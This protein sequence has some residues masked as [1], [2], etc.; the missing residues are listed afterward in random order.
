MMM[1]A[2]LSMSG[3]GPA[4]DEPGQ[5]MPLLMPRERLLAACRQHPI[6]VAEAPSG[7]GKSA[8]ATSWLAAAAPG[9]HCLWTAL[10]A[11]ARD[12]AVFLD[13]LIQSGTGQAPDWSGKLLD[14][15]ASLAVRFAQVSALLADD[16]QPIAL[17]LDNVH[18]LDGSRSRSYLQRLLAA[19]NPRLRIFIVMNPV[20]LEAGLA[21]LGVA[22]KLHWINAAM[23]AFSREEIEQLAVLRGK[24]LSAAQLDWLHTAT[25]GWPALVQLALLL[26][27]DR[28]PLPEA[29]NTLGPLG[30]LHEYLYDRFLSR[31]DAAGRELMWTMACLGRGT[32]R[33]LLAVHESSDQTATVLGT[34][35]DLG[36]VRHEP[37]TEPSFQLN[38]LVRESSL[39]LLAS[40]RCRSK[41]EILLAAA[42]WYRHQGMSILAVRMLLETEGHDTAMVRDWLLELGHELIFQQGQHQTLLDLEAL[43]RSVA[44]HR[45]PLLDSM[46]CWAL[47]FQRRFEEAQD[48]IAP[49]ASISRDSIAASEAT[50]QRAVIAAL[51][52]DLHAGGDL[53]SIWLSLNPEQ[54][55][56]QAGAAWTV[57]AF[58][59]KSQGRISEAQAALRDAHLSFHRVQSSYGAVWAHLVGALA[60]V[61]SGQ[62]RDALVEIQSGVQLCRNGGLDGM[63]AMLRATE[64]YIRYERDELSKVRD[65]LDEALPL[66]AEQGV[67]DSVV[68]GYAAAAR[69]RAAEGDLGAALDLLSEAERSG[70][71]RE[72]RRLSISLCAERA[73]ILVRNGASGQA[74]ETAQRADIRLDHSSGERLT[75]DRAGRLFA[76]IALADGDADQALRIVAPQLAR[77][78][79][80]RNQYKRCELLILT[81]LAESLAAH[82]AAAATALREALEIA[83]AE[84]YVRV[85]IDEGAELLVLLRRWLESGNRG[86]PGDPASLLA[87]AILTRMNRVEMVIPPNRP[88][89]LDALSKR[90]LQLLQL[91]HQGLSNAEIAARCFLVEG[92]VKWHLHNLY[93]KLGVSSRTAALREAKALGLLRS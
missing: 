2:S 67:V 50:L 42:A 60:L 20:A 39:R 61:K 3:T 33:L 78:R 7:Y 19:A 21:A 85:F 5:P 18:H 77:V 41:G 84:G 6:I 92:T 40:E 73:L 28:Q 57:F 52:D 62:H 9:S 87:E 65:L 82:H 1:D 90:E 13:A 14:D 48:R 66:L 16:A 49:I 88:A 17:V 93:G 27:N 32:M 43:W 64:A 83:A 51:R 74:R 15:D 47:I 36:V 71:Q 23:L 63:H 24:T 79:T 12:P 38:P 54:R 8:L 68:L 91:I 69:L 70:Q 59:L 45:D 86:R 26:I 58:N 72:F 25:Q 44:G 10:D 22:G 11:S 56:F 89:L 4:P 55:S 31:L 30:P 80:A 46:A 34:L 37:G 35:V 76:R 29:V 53:A 81:A 75:Q